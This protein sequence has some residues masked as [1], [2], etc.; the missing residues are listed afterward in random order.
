MIPTPMATPLPRSFS[1]NPPNH[2]GT[3]AR[4]WCL[5]LWSQ[6]REGFYE[7]HQKKGGSPLKL[8]I[9]VHQIWSTSLKKISSKFF[10]SW[11][12]PCCW[13]LTVSL[14][15]I[16]HH[17]N[18][19]RTGQPQ[20]AQPPLPNP[21]SSRVAKSHRW[22]DF[23]HDENL[24][25]EPKICYENYAPIAMGTHNLHFCRLLPKILGWQL[26]FGGWGGPWLLKS[27]RNLWINLNNSLWSS[28]QD[29][30]LKPQ[31]SV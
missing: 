15:Q 10:K 26:P 23:F 25:C 31:V 1:K 11:D 18:G 29:W 24:L 14:A 17:P 19:A 28:R 9:H 13:L 16:S 8:P 22:N 21:S 6:F 20:V 4:L 12:S 27:H 2:L 7:A 30:I 3:A 5:Q